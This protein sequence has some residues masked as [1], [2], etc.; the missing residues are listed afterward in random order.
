MGSGREEEGRPGVISTSA[1]PRCSF[2][3]VF[4]REEKSPRLLD[5]THFGS[6]ARTQDLSPEI[7][8]F[9]HIA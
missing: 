8:L 2:R 6:A 5:A 3:R 1:W 4:M 7:L 9:Q